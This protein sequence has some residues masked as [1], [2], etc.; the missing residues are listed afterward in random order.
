[1]GGLKLGEGLGGRWGQP[2]DVAGGKTIL[3]W[4]DDCVTRSTT[5]IK[6]NDA[7]TCFGTD[8]AFLK[9]SVNK[10]CET[11]TRGPI[12]QKHPHSKNMY[13]VVISINFTIL[14]H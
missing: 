5:V 9:N 10:N 14:K 7:S 6:L 1:M 2:G 11:V 12:K 3:N 13:N 4:S 8:G